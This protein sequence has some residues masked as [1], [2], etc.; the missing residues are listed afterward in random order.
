MYLSLRKLFFA[1]SLLFAVLLLVAMAGCNTN[2]NS[3]NGKTDEAAPNTNEAQEIITFNNAVVAFDDRNNDYLSHVK[4]NIAKIVEKIQSP[5]TPNYLDDPSESPLLHPDA[6]ITKPPTS[7]S[8]DDQ[9]FFKTNLSSM[10]DIYGQ[11]KTTYKSLYSYMQ[12]E[13]FKDDDYAK[14]KSM[15]VQLNELGTKYYT[16]EGA[17]I[18]K[19]ATVGDAAERTLLKDN[20]L[21][22][23][24]Y[25]LKDDNAAVAN[26]NGLLDSA[27]GNY[28]ASAERA[29]AAYAQLNGQY[30]KHSVATFPDKTNYASQRDAFRRY[31]TTLNEYLLFV[32]KLMRNAAGSGKIDESD[33]EYMR[34]EQDALRTYYN[35]FVG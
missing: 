25:A 33:L 24:I 26:L 5:S 9:A 13:D 7:L 23:L 6:D 35:D 12:A 34:Q 29:S 18:Q 32:R 30:S 8:Q 11:I 27:A 15:V 19:L 21:K 31:Y 3:A 4:D 22:D 16:V 14:G 1:E 17:V 28:K 10:T 20:P 2:N